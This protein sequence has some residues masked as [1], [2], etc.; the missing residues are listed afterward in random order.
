MSLGTG[1]ASTAT[2]YRGKSRHPGGFFAVRRAVL[3]WA[4]TIAGP[5]CLAGIAALFLFANPAD[6]ANVLAFYALCGFGSFL[7]SWA[8]GYW[9]RLNVAADH[10][11]PDDSWH[12]TRQALLISM[13]VMASLLLL[14]IGWLGVPAILL[15]AASVVGA[16]FF[17]TW[18]GMRN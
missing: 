8:A 11:H 18:M 16:E 10:E 13:G 17:F 5:A 2:E 6:P 1:V 7:G 3:L 4:A 12:C 15:M 14:R 9:I